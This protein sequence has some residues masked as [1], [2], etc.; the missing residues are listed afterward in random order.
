MKKTVILFFF[1]LLSLSASAEVV[2][3]IL[4]IVNDEIIT[5]Q[6]LESYKKK[7]RTG[8]FIDDLLLSDKNKVLADPKALLEHLINERIIDSEVKRQD[9]AVTVEKVDQEIRGIA[10]NNGITKNQLADEI[11]KQGVSFSEYQQFVKQRLERQALIQKTISSKI[12]ISEEEIQNYYISNNKTS[13]LTSYEY[14][15]AHILFLNKNSK[16]EAKKRAQSILEKV[17]AGER[18]DDLAS[19]YSEDPNFSTGGFLGT[20]KSGEFLKELE[21]A[22]QN[23]QPGQ[24]SKIVETKLGFHI[25]K[26]TGKKIIKDPNYEAAKKQIQNILYEKAFAQQFKFWIEQRKAESFVKINS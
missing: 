26:V 25:L 4:A 12:K 7:I 16:S 3:K 9:L 13:D 8:K 19:Q 11:K 23:L 20:F 6:D 5:Q 17:N 18:F 22:V 15:L 24:T 2:D 10:R 21:Q 1:C 14:S